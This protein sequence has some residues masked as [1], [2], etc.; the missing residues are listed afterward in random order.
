MKLKLWIIG[1]A[2]LVS[3]SPSFAGGIMMMGGGVAASTPSSSTYIGWPNSDG[4]PTGT[5][6]SAASIGDDAICTTQWTAT[7]NGTA[8][9]IQFYSGPLWAADGA[10]V[11]LYRN[12]S[13]TI[14]LVGS[15]TVTVPGT[16]QWIAKATLTA[17]SGQSLDFS[18]NDVLYYGVYYYDTL[19][20]SSNIGREDAGGSGMYYVT[21][22]GETGTPPATTTFTASSSRLMS[23]I[24]E[25]E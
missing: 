4:T 17:E 16:S 9:T 24:L 3:A 2:L 18:T 1:L 19:G 5:P 6:A 25:Y 10:K 21:L 13:G 22:T 11:V 23:F 20:S 8:K 12:I 7:E 15:G 14:T